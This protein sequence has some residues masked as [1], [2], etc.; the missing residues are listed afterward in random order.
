MVALVCYC[1]SWCQ[2]RNKLMMPMNKS[3]SMNKSNSEDMPMMSADEGTADDSATSDTDAPMEHLEAFVESLTPEERNYVEKLI[4]AKHK[5]ASASKMGEV[6]SEAFDK[7]KKGDVNPD[8][9]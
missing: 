4:E 5:E 8:G 7:A 1:L 6:T 2:E 3:M 9:Y